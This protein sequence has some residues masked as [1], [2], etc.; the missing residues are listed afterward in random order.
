[1][2]KSENM[3]KM[4][5]DRRLHRRVIQIRRMAGTAAI[6]KFKFD[7]GRNI[8]NIYYNTHIMANTRVTKIK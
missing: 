6:Q 1:M 8:F 3:T 7:F 4:S 2:S 5:E